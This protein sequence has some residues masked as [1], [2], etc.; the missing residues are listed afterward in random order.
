VKRS[1]PHNR[2]VIL[3]QMSHPQFVTRWPDFTSKRLVQLQ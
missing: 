3:A 2:S 1:H